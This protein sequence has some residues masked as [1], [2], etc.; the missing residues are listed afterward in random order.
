MSSSVDDEVPSVSSSASLIHSTLPGV[1]NTFQ[2]AV[3]IDDDDEEEEAEKAEHGQLDHVQVDSTRPHSTSQATLEPRHDPTEEDELIQYRFE[4]PNP[5]SIF[6]LVAYVLV[7]YFAF[8]ALN[9][10][11]LVRKL[12]IYFFIKIK[13]I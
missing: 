2:Q 11:S 1:V 4:P 6:V 10:I 7:I 5:I 3:S 12:L 13:V 8:E 9:L